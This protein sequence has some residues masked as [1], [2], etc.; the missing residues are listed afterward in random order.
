MPSAGKTRLDCGRP[1]RNRRVAAANLDP[2]RIIL[3]LGSCNSGLTLW[4]VRAD[5]KVLRAKT[6]NAA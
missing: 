4:L 1:A 5:T 6:P 2:N 3:S